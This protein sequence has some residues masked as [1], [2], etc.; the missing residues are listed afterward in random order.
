MSSAERTTEMV[1]LYAAGALPAEEAAEFEHA[2]ASGD[3]AALRAWSEFAPVV[4]ALAA[5]AAAPAPQSARD[6]LLERAS[7]GAA[8]QPSWVMIRSAFGQW[9]ETGI[10]GVQLKSLFIDR[11]RNIH[12]FLL[13]VAPGTQVP[14]HAHSGPE[15]CFVV[16]GD[17]HTYDTILRDGDYLRADARTTHPPSFTRDGCTLLV[18]AAIGDEEELEH[19]HNQV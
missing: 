10:P 3:P 5:V 13:R 8:P 16:S 15:E 18:T 19:E 12:T 4:Q 2:L 17:L 9:A 14:T 6:W 11:L 7:N 1:S